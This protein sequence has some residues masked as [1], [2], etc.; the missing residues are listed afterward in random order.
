MK[1]QRWIAWCLFT[2][3][4]VWL[5]AL[6]A[7]LARDG[8]AWAPD[9][10][11]VFVFSV[12][13][14]L[15]LKELP[16]LLVCALV[17]RASL[18]VEP[19][20]ALA[21]GLVGVALAVFAARGVFELTAPAWRTLCC[22]G[23]VFAFDAWLVFVARVRGNGGEPFASALVS[24]VPATIMTGLVSLAFGPALAHLPGLTPLRSRKW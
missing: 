22:A 13:A 12:L 2:V 18:A 19:A 6:H 10:G 3:W 9:L 17:A 4:L 14:R 1:S 7:I 15:E 20:A 5:H 24:L 11:L 21:A 16:W 23:V 8:S